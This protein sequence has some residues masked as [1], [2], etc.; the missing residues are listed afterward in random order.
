MGDLR[1]IFN[2]NAA[3]WWRAANQR[4]GRREAKADPRRVRPRG[5]GL[6]PF[7]IS[8]TCIGESSSQ[9]VE[10]PK[11]IFRDSTSRLRAP[12]YPV[13]SAPGFPLKPGWLDCVDIQDHSI[14]A[15]VDVQFN[16]AYLLSAI[17]LFLLFHTSSADILE[18]FARVDTRPPQDSGREAPPRGV[19]GLQSIF[20]P[21][22]SPQARKRPRLG[23]IRL[24]RGN[25]PSCESCDG[26]GSALMRR[27]HRRRPVAVCF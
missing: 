11:N 26:C 15:S 8:G 25:L 14:T 22:W 2:T 9:P 13:A 10:V 20:L 5:D 23:R 18:L 24:R 3:I 19:R 17:Q 1:H 4:F 16:F 12:L 21:P 7:T 6:Y 27:G